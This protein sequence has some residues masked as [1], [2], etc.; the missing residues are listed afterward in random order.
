MARKV[1]IF[2]GQWADL[3]LKKV[4]ELMADFGY[5]G[6][7]LCT[8]GDHFDIEKAA[9]SKS[10][11]DDKRELLT[12]YGLDCW[13]ISN[14]LSGQLVCDPIDARHYAFAPAKLKNDPKAA[15]KW[16]IDMQKKRLRRHAIWG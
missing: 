3:P 1:T 14:H 15:R 8:W 11:C 4:C 2:T 16:A 12:T 10:Y 6:L 7:E 9:R 5:D 13:S